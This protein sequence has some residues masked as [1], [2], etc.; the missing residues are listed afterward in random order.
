M[1]KIVFFVSIILFLATGNISC[2]KKSC[3]PEKTKFELLTMDDWNMYK[4]VVS[5][6]NGSTELPMDYRWVFTVTGHFYYYD[7]TGN[8]V[9]EGTFELEDADPTLLHMNK[10]PNVSYTYTV[11]DLTEDEMKWEYESGNVTYTFYLRRN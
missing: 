10:P 11:L 5:N 6:G 3:E 9:E 2:K 4:E 7:D 1:K 8:L